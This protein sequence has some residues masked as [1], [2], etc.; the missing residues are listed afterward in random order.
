[1]ITEAKPG[2]AN[3]LPYGGFFWWDDAVT[4]AQRLALMSGRRRRVVFD[5][6]RGLW[7][8]RPALERA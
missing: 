1:M 8:V 3:P 4:Y 5:R 2:A 7:V 6:V